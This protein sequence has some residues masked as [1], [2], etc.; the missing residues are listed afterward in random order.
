[1]TFFF[2]LTVSPTLLSADITSPT[3]PGRGTQPGSTFPS[4]YY[5]TFSSCTNE[6]IQ[7]IIVCVGQIVGY[8]FRYLFAVAL[9]VF[10]WGVSKTIRAQ[11]DEEK[12]KE[13]RRVMF[14]GIIALFVMVSI[15]GLVAFLQH[16]LTQGVPNS[17]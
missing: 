14:W 10:L 13:G 4:S 8:S 5:Q 11:G 3:I 16:D 1:M 7:G 6:N 17:L 9:L 15:S 2:L 12:I